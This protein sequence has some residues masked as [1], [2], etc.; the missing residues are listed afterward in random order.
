VL[1]PGAKTPMLISNELV[2]RM[3]PGSVLVDISID[4]GGCFED[5]HPTTHADPTYRVHN[6]V[7]YCVANMPG[8]VPHTST[9]A[10]TNVTLRYAV[11]LANLGVKAAFDRVFAKLRADGEDD[12][13]AV[14]QFIL[15][16]F[17]AAGMWAEDAPIVGVN[18]N[19]ADP[20]YRPGPDTSAP[21]RRGDFLLIDLFAKE[22]A[23]DSVYADITWCGVCAPAPT[24]RQEEIFRTV[25][26]GRDAA[27]ELV[28]SRYPHTTV[29]GFEV[30]DAARGPIVAA[31]Y[32]EQFIH[33]TGHGIGT[34]T[35]E[36][37]YMIEGE[38]QA[39]ASL[40]GLGPAEPDDAKHRQA[41]GDENQQHGPRITPIPCRPWPPST[42]RRPSARHPVSGT[43]P[44]A[45]GIVDLQAQLPA[46]DVR[47][48][49]A[50]R[51]ECLLVAHLADAEQIAEVRGLVVPVLA[52]QGGGHRGAGS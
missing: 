4:Q 9:Y 22:K 40:G 2:S 11:A 17:E 41:K 7:F 34:T 18:A 26:A 42:S 15:E 31:G 20:H 16:R 39:P 10:L 44:T 33:R 5:S 23:A 19:S 14:Q 45:A 30:D 35:H 48:Q 8:A 27:V 43:P 38:E 50:D 52:L 12:E 3:L 13:S 46:Q 36:P 29:R 25:A 47:P 49:L 51:G 1:V 6:S 28:T 37:P 21:I 32:G 24:D